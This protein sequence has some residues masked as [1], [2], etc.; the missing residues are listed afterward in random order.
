[1]VLWRCRRLRSLL[2]APK[3]KRKGQWLEGPGRL[4]R[5]WKSRPFRAGFIW[6]ETR[7]VAPGYFIAARWA[8]KWVFDRG[9][10]FYPQ[11]KAGFSPMFGPIFARRLVVF[12]GRVGC[13]EAIMRRV[14]TPAGSSNLF[15]SKPSPPAADAAF[16]LGSVKGRVALA[17][18][19]GEEERPDG[20]RDP[21]GRGGF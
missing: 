9:T 8:F 17:S 18:S 20:W 11:V 21:G 13:R 3:A 14:A 1:V 6:G 4:G 10:G 16:E 19:E 15:A 7:G 12:L 5:I 2:R